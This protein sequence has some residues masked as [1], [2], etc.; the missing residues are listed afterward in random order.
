MGDT[1]AS[2]DPASQPEF[3]TSQTMIYPIRSLL[4]DVQPSHD[5]LLPRRPT[6][7][8]PVF[9]RDPILAAR[10]STAGIGPE[11]TSMIMPVHTL[12]RSASIQQRRTAQWQANISDRRLTASG[13]LSSPAGSESRDRDGDGDEDSG[14]VSPSQPRSPEPNGMPSEHLC[15]FFPC[16]FIY[17]S[18]MR[19]SR[20]CERP[21]LSAMRLRSMGG[22]GTQH[23]TLAGIGTSSTF[24][25]PSF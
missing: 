15:F 11:P 8:S 20:S 22:N 17:C 19:A 5:P 12:R 24:S 9:P 2:P 23:L 3:A 25:F 14:L 13:W 4:S 21:R 1:N 10:R 16:H 18:K 7:A 6:T